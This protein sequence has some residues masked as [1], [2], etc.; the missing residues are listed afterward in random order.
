MTLHNL[1]ATIN[2][3]LEATITAL[4]ATIRAHENTIRA[5]RLLLR[6]QEH[7]TQ[8]YARCIRDLEAATSTF[9]DASDCREEKSLQSQADE[10]SQDRSF[11]TNA[12]TAMPA[13]AM[14]AAVPGT[15]EG[16]D[17]LLGFPGRTSTDAGDC[18][19]EEEGSFVTADRGEG[20]IEEAICSSP[21]LDKIGGCDEWSR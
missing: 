2:P 17:Q 18:G 4:R 3:T 10:H 9:S 21:A 1:T 13:S 7:R 20:T 5:Q 6:D 11:T 8:A 15:E 19:G 12:M 16:V 14:I